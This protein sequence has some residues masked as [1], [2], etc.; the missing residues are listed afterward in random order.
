MQSLLGF[1]DSCLSGGVVGLGVVDIEVRFDYI[2][3]SV[4]TY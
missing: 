4:V 2:G 1:V 3:R